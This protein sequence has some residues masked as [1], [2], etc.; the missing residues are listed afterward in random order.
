MKG[1]IPL[2]PNNIFHLIIRA[3]ITCRV[4]VEF[5]THSSLGNPMQCR[6]PLI[7]KEV[8]IIDWLTQCKFFWVRR[9]SIW[10]WKMDD[11]LAQLNMGANVNPLCKKD[12]KTGYQL[13]SR[14]NSR[15][16]WSPLKHFLAWIQVTWE[17]ASSHWDSPVSL[18]P[19]DGSHQTD[20]F[21]RWGPG[22][23][24]SLLLLLSSGT[25]YPSHVRLAPALLSF[26]KGLK[27]RF[28]QSVWVP[29]GGI[30]QWRWLIQW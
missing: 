4:W 1:F 6:N 19:A 29:S 18:V 25:S 17:I 8:W 21:D 23:G 26:R 13:A 7:W 16:C 22:V 24:P 27:T 30:A 20:Y 3:V 11:Y 15:F 2:F 9:G 10:W 14:C 5:Q 28:C 12:I